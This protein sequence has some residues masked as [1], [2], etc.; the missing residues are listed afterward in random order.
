MWRWP[1]GHLLKRSTRLRGAPVS[2]SGPRLLCPRAAPDSE[3]E[4]WSPT[5]STNQRTD[6]PVRCSDG[7]LVDHGA[8]ERFG[9]LAHRTH[10][11]FELSGRRLRVAARPHGDDNVRPDG[12][13]LLAGTAAAF[14]AVGDHRDGQDVVVELHGAD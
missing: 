4:P 5:I 12:H 1:R 13:R 6:G 9:L 3:G 11:G 7:D 2:H 8:R 14:L 10:V